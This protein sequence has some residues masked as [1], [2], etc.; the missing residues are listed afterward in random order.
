MKEDL[1]L[2]SEI[3]KIS[4]YVF[5][6]ILIFRVH[7]FEI[8]LKTITYLNLFRMTCSQKDHVH[9]WYMML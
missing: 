7:T 6:H 4:F 3:V 1:S 2:N 5:P 9:E 8:I